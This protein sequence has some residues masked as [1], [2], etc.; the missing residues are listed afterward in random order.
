MKASPG[1]KYPKKSNG[2]TSP[3]YAGEINVQET[4]SKK[5]TKKKTSKKSA[6]KKGEES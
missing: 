6:V 2:R 3:I 4:E 5:V 1:Y